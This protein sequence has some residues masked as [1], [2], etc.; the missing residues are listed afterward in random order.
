ARYRRAV[1]EDRT[2]KELESLV[3]AAARK[4]IGITGHEQLKTA[5]RGYPKDHPRIDLLR[6][7]GLVAWQEWPPAPWLGTKKA[8]DRVIAFL[9]ATDPLAE[10]LDTNVGESR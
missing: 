8:K 10:W 9:H 1:D 6:N 2:G 4:K 5:P 3:A 7:K